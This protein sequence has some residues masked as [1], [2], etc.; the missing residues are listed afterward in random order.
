MPE[1][2]PFHRGTSTAHA[3]FATTSSMPC[4]RSGPAASLASG[5]LAQ[6][7]YFAPLLWI[8]RERA[9]AQ[10]RPVLAPTRSWFCGQLRP[11]PRA[12][13]AHL[14]RL[15]EDDEVDVLVFALDGLADRS[16]LAELIRDEPDLVPIGHLR[17]LLAHDAM[18]V[19][20]AAAAR[21][22][23]MHLPEDCDRVVAH[24]AAG[25]KVQPWYAT[26]GLA[27]IPTARRCSRTPAISA[28]HSTS[29]WRRRCAGLRADFPWIRRRVEVAFPASHHS[30]TGERDLEYASK[31]VRDDGAR[32]AHGELRLH[33]E[34]FRDM[35]EASARRARGAAAIARAEPTATGDPRRILRMRAR[36]PRTLDAADALPGGTPRR[37]HA[38]RLGRVWLLREYPAENPSSAHAAFQIAWIERGYG[39]RITSARITPGY[40]RSASRRAARG[41]RAAPAGIMPG[42]GPGFDRPPQETSPKRA[43]SALDA[44]LPSVAATYLPPGS[45]AHEKARRA[46]REHVSRVKTGCPS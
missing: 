41:P 26:Y 9:E 1:A 28:L 6:H 38:H 10:A 8:D 35:L 3:S 11:E 24:L 34:C 12:L 18:P 37:P 33:H 20:D 27:R 15:L 2:V 45:D 36:S 22:V 5:P 21:L 19:R 46:A 25:H 13:A 32:A 7:R 31:I 4:A 40:A 43:R 30:S 42:P 14:R 17:R 29:Y 16:Y 44:G 23:D 39:S